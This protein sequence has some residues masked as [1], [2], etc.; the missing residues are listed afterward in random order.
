[1]R[2]VYSVNLSF[3][4]LLDKDGSSTIHQGNVLSLAIEIYKYLH[5]LSPAI[6]SEV[7]KVNEIILYDLRMRNELYASYFL[8]RKLKRKQHYLFL[9]DKWEERTN[10]FCV[11]N[12][13]SGK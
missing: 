5:G 1:M 3:Y 12:V 6:L 2:N 7:F 4:E 13:Y 10:E 8:I 11:G 9:L